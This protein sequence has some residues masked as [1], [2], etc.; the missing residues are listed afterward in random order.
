[1]WPIEKLDE[2]E[3]G[4]GSQFHPGKSDPFCFNIVCDEKKSKIGHFDSL[5][6]VDAIWP[7]WE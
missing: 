7:Q 3:E 6:A 5:Q 4:A 1:M 2:Q